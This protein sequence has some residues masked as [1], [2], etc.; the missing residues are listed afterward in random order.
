MSAKEVGIRG[1][2]VCVLR[3]L[4]GVS[5]LR[6]V[7]KIFPRYFIFIVKYSAHMADR[8]NSCS[9]PAIQK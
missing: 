7:A 9:Q 8:G 6:A 1:V 5:L 4:K 3:E 2:C